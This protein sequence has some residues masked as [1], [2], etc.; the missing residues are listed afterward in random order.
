MATTKN[1]LYVAC[2]TLSWDGNRS[3]FGV[4]QYDERLVLTKDGMSR[5]NWRLPELPAFSG[6]VK[7]KIS[8]SRKDAWR[9]DPQHGE[10]Y[11]VAN[12]GQEFVIEETDA[13][14]AW[15]RSLIEGC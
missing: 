10:Y 7:P 15:A 1:C 2:E 12:I 14:E 9:N 5:S 13:V 8:S 4:F 6:S 3:R 11:R